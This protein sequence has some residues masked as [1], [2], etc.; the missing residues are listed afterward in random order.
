MQLKLL[1]CFSPAYDQYYDL[2]GFNDFPDVLAIIEFRVRWEKDHTGGASITTPS[3]SDRSTWID[4]DLNTDSM[5]DIDLIDGDSVR[6]WVWAKDI[7][8][9]TNEDEVLVHFDSSPPEIIGFWL[10]HDGEVDVYVHNL[11]ELHEME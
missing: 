4:E 11:E 10:V 5:Y 7:V 1:Y 8:N 3:V 2:R 9:Q 6:L